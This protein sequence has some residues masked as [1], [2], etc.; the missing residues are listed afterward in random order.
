MVADGAE[1]ALPRGGGVRGRPRRH[2]PAEG[3]PL[4]APCRGLARG[5][6]RRPARPRDDLAH[7]DAALAAAP[8]ADP[9]AGAGRRRRRRLHRADEPPARDPD[10][11]ARALRGAG[12][13]LR[14][15]RADEPAR[16][17]RHGH[18]L[19]HLPRRRP[20][21]VRPRPLQLRGRHPAAARARRPPGG[22][23]LLGDR[24]G[25]LRAAARRAGARRL[26][27]RL[28]R[29]VPA[30]VDARARRRAEPPAA[31]RELRARRRGLP[32]RRRRG[33]RARPD[34]LQRL[35]AR[36]LGGADQPQR[37]APLARDRRRLL[38]GAPVRARRVR[39]R[40]RLEPARGDRALVR[41]G[42]RA[43][44][45]PRRRR[46][47]RGLPRRCSPIRRRRRSWAAAPASACSTSTRTR[48]ARG[49]C[50]SC[51]TWA[52]RWPPVPDVVEQPAR[53]GRCCPGSPSCAASRSCR[54]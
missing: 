27:L 52:S 40:D 24:P 5:H 10:G 49:G 37:H 36:D 34:P 51:S 54:R 19:Q 4:P 23:A 8:G 30:R 53:G 43:A 3:R 29:Q 16:V 25:A 26:L 7:G 9:R 39:G 18:G 6:A 41:A 14:R 1:P 42:Q 46:G 45:R 48:T 47:D 35:P 17:R 33:A 28:R 22:A 12:R 31:G 50:S 32:R 21:R 2:R 13:L 11:A 15:R 20:V 44:R 38:D